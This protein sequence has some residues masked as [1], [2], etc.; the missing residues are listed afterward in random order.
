MDS[1]TRFPCSN[2]WPLLYKPTTRLYMDDLQRMS[3]VDYTTFSF[4]CLYR[5]WANDW[6]V[7]GFVSKRYPQCMVIDSGGR[8]GA[9]SLWT[10]RP[11]K[12]GCFQRQG[13]PKCTLGHHCPVKNGYLKRACQ[14]CPIFQTCN[15]W[16]MKPSA[17]LKDL[18]FIALEL[19]SPGTLSGLCFCTEPG[20]LQ[21]CWCRM[22][23]SPSGMCW[24]FRI[25]AWFQKHLQ[26]L[27]HFNTFGVRYFVQY[28]TT[29]LY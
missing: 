8:L 25:G 15:R 20:A 17:H 14:A 6:L 5:C 4:F 13:I 10:P 16:M 1:K 23:A 26:Q 27:Q 3:R 7:Y 11:L 18:F 9:W 28:I 21:L 2:I 24:A 22:Y 19:P 12:H 29:R